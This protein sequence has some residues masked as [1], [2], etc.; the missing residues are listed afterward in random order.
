MH[1][2][3]QIMH[4]L[5]QIM[6]YLM[7]DSVL[8]MTQSTFSSKQSSLDEGCVIVQCFKSFD[9]IWYC[10]CLWE[11]SEIMHQY[12]WCSVAFAGSFLAYRKTPNSCSPKSADVHTCSGNTDLSQGKWRN[13]TR[14]V[15]LPERK[16]PAPSSVRAFLSAE[17]QTHPY[18]NT[19]LSNSR[20][21]C[22][23]GYIHLWRWCW[24]HHSPRWN[25]GPSWESL[26]FPW[27][28]LVSPWGCSWLW[29]RC[30]Y[31][32]AGIGELAGSWSFL[33]M[34]PILSWDTYLHQPGGDLGLCLSSLFSPARVHF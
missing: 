12:G 16:M 26:L 8:H 6:H 30:S 13:L 19:D 11:N 23:W 17:R 4:G 7:S 20:G 9:K 34:A 27:K 25:P 15:G 14:D 1:W 31:F 28:R 2:L 5:C 3:H 18:S 21:V 33:G 22:R 24:I 32:Q 29:E 10:Q